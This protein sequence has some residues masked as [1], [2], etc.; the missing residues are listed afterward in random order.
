M[1]HDLTEQQRW[2]VAYEVDKVPTACW[3]DLVDWALKGHSDVEIE[4]TG[5]MVA[6]P[7][8]EISGGGWCAMNAS[9]EGGTCY[10]GK[11]RTV[12]RELTA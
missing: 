12:G 10:C 9:S 6:Q 11:F 5:E 7:V 3:A 4:D 1:S 2:E 8:P